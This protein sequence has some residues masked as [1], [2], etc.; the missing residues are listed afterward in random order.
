MLVGLKCACSLRVCVAD[1][2]LLTRCRLGSSPAAIAHIRTF[3]RTR[4]NHPFLLLCSPT[5]APTTDRS[6]L[7]LLAVVPLVLTI[8]PVA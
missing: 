3:H 8:S 4:T 1:Q 6:L 5:Y 7:P 2:S